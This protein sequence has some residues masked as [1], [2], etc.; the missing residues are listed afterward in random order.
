MFQ[1]FEQKKDRNKL[2]GIVI[3]L[4]GIFLFSS[5]TN[6]A[7]R[8]IARNTNSNSS[9][10]AQN[11]NQDLSKN[12]K[13]A[14]DAAITA[15]QSDN[16]R[17]AETNAKK[18]LALAPRSPAVNKYSGCCF[19]KLGCFNEAQAAFQTALK[20]DPKFISARNNFANLLATQGKIQPAIAELEKVLAQNPNYLQAHFNLGTLYAKSGNFEKASLHLGKIREAEPNDLVLALTF[21][22][23]AYRGGKKPEADVLADSIEANFS[24]NTRVYFTLR[25]DACR[26]RR[27]RTRR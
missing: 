10:K 22:S 20:Y 14:L 15:L 19:R 18:A 26:R 13:I 4:T 17:D 25:T 6:F 8:K 1:N 21:I 2:F 27:I 12:A 7:Q 24:N 3:I 5:H 16:L 9:D 11:Q 23:V